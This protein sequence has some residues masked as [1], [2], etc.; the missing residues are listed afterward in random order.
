MTK[1]Q[2]AV[3]FPFLVGYL[4]MQRCWRQALDF[5]AC[6][7]VTFGATLL[8][9]HITSDG[10]FWFYVFTVPGAAPIQPQLQHDFWT[11][12][13]LPHFYPALS[14]I[15]LS[16]CTLV[17]GKRWN[18]LR[19]FLTSIGVMGVP[20]LAMSYLSMSK[21]WGFVNG[22]IP[23]A[24]AV[25]LVSAEAAHYA[26]NT[27]R[28]PQT[29][30]FSSFPISLLMSWLTLLLVLGQFFVLRYDVAGAIPSQEDKL[31][32]QHTVRLLQQAPQ[33]VFAST[34]PDLLSIAGQPLHFH[35]SSLGDLNLAAQSNESVKAMLAPYE[36][37]I[38]A[39]LRNGTIRTAVLPKVDW[40]DWA[41]KTEKYQC[42]EITPEQRVSTLSGARSTLATVCSKRD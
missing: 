34:V 27:A 9:M 12:H 29:E 1:Q 23:L 41:F 22:I 30:R 42:Q 40:Y 32:V 35:P 19:N 8:V 3:A 20:M 33:P 7:V 31:A 16:V 2:A 38:S 11:N 10:W 17:M 15:A 18:A 39:P 36:A 5:G 14:A 26:I 24:V 37:G 4:L 6:F 21:Q 25:A 13:V 28:L